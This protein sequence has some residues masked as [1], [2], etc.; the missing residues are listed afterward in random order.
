M[1]ANAEPE[2]QGGRD[3]GGWKGLLEVMSLEVL[4]ESVGTVTAAQS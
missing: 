3:P 2:A 4:A 1:S